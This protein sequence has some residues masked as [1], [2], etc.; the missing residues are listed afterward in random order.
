MSH[1]SFLHTHSEAPDRWRPHGPWQVI[2][3]R[4]S[5]CICMYITASTGN[6]GR[7]GGAA[8]GNPDMLVLVSP[9]GPPQ[10]W[11]KLRHSL[12]NSC[13]TSAIVQSS[14][15]E[16]HSAV[17]QCFHSKT[18]GRTSGSEKRRAM[19]LQGCFYEGTERALRRGKCMLVK[20]QK[21]KKTCHIFLFFCM[22]VYH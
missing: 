22:H 12:V 8:R 4:C 20:K 15:R 16:T 7:S 3:P 11:L 1:L 5:V 17:E 9:S 2:T 14:R 21:T 6:E 19:N 13:Y 10:L 18:I